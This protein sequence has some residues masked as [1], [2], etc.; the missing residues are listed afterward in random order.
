MREGF[1]P[2]LEANLTLAEEANKRYLAAASEI[3]GSD[4]EINFTNSEA[5]YREPDKSRFLR[6]FTISRDGTR[7]F[8]KM[9][10]TNRNGRQLR[11]EAEAMQIADQLGAKT[12]RQLKPYTETS[13]GLAGMHLVE[14]LDPKDGQSLTNKEM[15]AGA[16]A[17]YGEWAGRAIASLSGREIPPEINSQILKRDDD[18]NS[19]V[20]SFWQVWHNSEAKIFDLPEDQQV[21]LS[22][23]Q[24][25]E[26]R[27]ALR[28]IAAAVEADIMADF[29]EKKLYFVHN[30]IAPNNIFFNQSEQSALLIDYEYGGATHSQLLAQYTDYGNFMLAAGRTPKCKKL[31]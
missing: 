6:G 7:G 19:S 4:T 23:T 27:S 26:Y 25:A 17:E 15:I 16:S 13:D 30:D 12:V 8:I 14:A 29:D 28:D 10:P 22:Q 21:L 9:A 31:F 3:T 1:R 18:R 24:I 2:G 20:E 5:F 11:R